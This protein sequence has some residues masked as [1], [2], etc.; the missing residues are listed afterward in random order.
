MNKITDSG[1]LF[2]NMDE[3]KVI[4]DHTGGVGMAVSPTGRPGKVKIEDVLN[5]ARLVL[6]L[7]AC[8]SPNPDQDLFGLS[9]A[10]KSL[11]ADIEKL[12]KYG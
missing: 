12:Q 1:R 2:N 6:N 7:V 9:D 4:D 3:T 5:K 8:T 11:V 10:I